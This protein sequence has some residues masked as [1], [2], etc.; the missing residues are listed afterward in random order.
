MNVTYS[1][2]C[3]FY[4]IFHNVQELPLMWIGHIWLRPN[5]LNKISIEA[6]LD[7]VDRCIPT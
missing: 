1:R 3:E 5:L 2:N 4:F 7:L 6:C